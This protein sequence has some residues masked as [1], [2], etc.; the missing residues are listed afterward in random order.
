M[1]EG[2][3]FRTSMGDTSKAP[4][5][6]LCIT[7]RVEDRAATEAIRSASAILINAEAVNVSRVALPII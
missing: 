1:Y 3:V 6:P 5:E 2:R 7:T 4:E